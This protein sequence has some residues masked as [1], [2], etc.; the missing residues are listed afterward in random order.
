[1]SWR[2]D[3]VRGGGGLVGFG[4]GGALAAWSGLLR[5][6]GEETDEEVGGLP[7]VF[8]SV[9]GQAEARDSVDACH[10]VPCAARVY[11]T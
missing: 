7:P 2:N 1:M 11:Q 3:L 4:C 8:R 9:R 6:R 5:W 10:A